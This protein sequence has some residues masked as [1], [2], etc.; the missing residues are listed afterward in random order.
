[1][2]RGK[3]EILYH[4]GTPDAAISLHMWHG[5]T[6]TT[7]ALCPI[8]SIEEVIKGGESGRTILL[9]H[10]MSHYSATGVTTEEEIGGKEGGGVRETMGAILIGIE[11]DDNDKDKDNDNSNDNNNNDDDDDENDDY[12]KDDNDYK[13]NDDND[14]DNDYGYKDGYRYEE[15][16][17]MEKMEKRGRGTN[18]ARVVPGGSHNLGEGTPS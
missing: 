11:G 9:F 8:Y 14:G 6:S 4:V 17:L 18:K 1:M 15:G 5:L 13:N 12:D 10:V 3:G 16:V 7:D 2:G